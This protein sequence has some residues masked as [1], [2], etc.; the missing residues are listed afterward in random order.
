M[1]IRTQGRRS[2][3]F[4]PGVA[5]RLE[6]GSENEVYGTTIEDVADSSILVLA[7]LK[8]EANLPVRDGT[9]I[10][11]VVERRNNPYLFD[12]TVVHTVDEEGKRFLRLT[13]PADNAGRQPRA[14]VRI[15]TLLEAQVWALD[16]DGATHGAPLTGTLLDLSQ[17]GAQV[18]LKDELPLEQELL[19]RVQLTKGGE[20]LT[21]YGTVRRIAAATANGLKTFRYGVQFEK[22]DRRIQDVIAK[23]LIVRERELL[24]KGSVNR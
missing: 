16:A 9:P 5:A 17:G 14:V 12:T 20:R 3:F 11:L 24:R 10:T 1:E 18:M 4:Q 7:P 6:L 13:R 8:G 15:P 21:L 2:V 19:I 23:Y 22:L